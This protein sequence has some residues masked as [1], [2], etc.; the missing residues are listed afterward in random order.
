M[1]ILRDADESIVSI[2]AVLG[3]SSQTEFAAFRK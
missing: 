3:L 2:A 1:N